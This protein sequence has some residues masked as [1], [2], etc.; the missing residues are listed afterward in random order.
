MGIAEP[1]LCPCIQRLIVII[2]NCF[3]FVVVCWAL[4]FLAC[5]ITCLRSI[6]VLVLLLYLSCLTYIDTRVLVLLLYLY[7]YISG[8]QN[9]SLGMA[10]N[11]SFY[12]GYFVEIC[13]RTDHINKHTFGRGHWWHADQYFCSIWYLKNI[14]E[15]ADSWLS[16]FFKMEEWDPGF[17]MR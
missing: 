6:R 11:P 16:L 13:H 7:W 2:V 4:V 12:I 15:L 8:S 1:V 9:T 17:R 10:P 5:T 14:V 3:V